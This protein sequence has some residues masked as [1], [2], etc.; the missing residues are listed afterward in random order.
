MSEKIWLKDVVNPGLL[1]DMIRQ[2]YIREQVHPTEP[3][4]IF[5][6][7]E[8]ATFE[9]TWNSATRLC[10]GL[11][12]Q[13]DVADG[14]AWV[15]AR[16]FPKFFNHNEPDAPKIGAEEPVYVTDKIDGSLG[17]R[18]WAPRAGRWK[19]ATR[20][21]FTSE[22]AEHGTECLARLLGQQ[23]FSN[24]STGEFTELYEIVYPENRIVL[25]YGDT[26]TLVYLGAVENRTGQVLPPDSMDIV[27]ARGYPGMGI[28]EVFEV[29]TFADALKLPDRKNAEGVVI[30][31]ADQRMVKLK[32]SDYVA[33]HKT[34]SN[35]SA[36]VI[37]ERASAGETLKDV[38]YGMPEELHDFIETTY[39]DLT[40][41]V[42]IT[43]CETKRIFEIITKT[44][45]EEHGMHNWG[46]KEFAE[47]ATASSY[48]DI[49]FLLLD[50]RDI[51]PVVWK[52]VKPK[53]EKPFRYR[54]K[55]VS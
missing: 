45:D 49:L 2:G 32:Q 47:L 3:L 38:K 55:D 4:L 46:R 12:V 10:R 9:R 20:G 24:E 54:S 5:N 52:Q 40:A 44:L 51:L 48:R 39:Q 37:W 8:K 43:L 35:L 33:M 6:Y 30:L 11:I 16:P 41:Q 14:A 28:T 26:D 19:I 27:W 31:T 13:Q 23:V 50:E 34:I 36:K 42:H 18:Y 25:D 15:I 22:Q 53:G 29:S 1:N 21:S 17:I 7:T